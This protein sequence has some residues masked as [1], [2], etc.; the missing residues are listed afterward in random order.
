VRGR[1]RPN[2][3]EDL[4][5]QSVTFRGRRRI[6]RL[7]TQIHA[8]E[9]FD[10]P[11]AG[12]VRCIRDPAFLVA[13]VRDGVGALSPWDRQLLGAARILAGETGAV[14]LLTSAATVDGGRA[15]ADRV[16]VAPALG[17]D[18]PGR[19]A[20]VLAALLAQ[21][22][23]RHTLLAESA[24]SGDLAR[25]VAAATGQA[26]FTDAELVRSGQLARPARARQ[27]ELTAAPTALIGVALDVAAEYAG[28]PREAAPLP[29]LEI[30]SEPRAAAFRGV[31]PIRRDPGSVPLAEADFVVA[32]GN[33]VTDFDSFR[34][35]VT[36][37]AATPGASRAVCD[38][39]L[40]PRD[41]QVGASGTVLDGSCYL[42]F[43]IA[44]APQHLQGVAR[45]EHVIAVNTDLHAAMIKRAA[46]AIVADAQQVMPALLRLVRAR[47]GA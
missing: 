23:P 39:G 10:A 28:P 34:A 16:V 29:A 22:R 40:M 17:D 3:R 35:L 46:L 2:P 41:R 37:L 32:A 33:G 15:G 24:A 5:R 11:R 14:L 47:S 36:A 4:S 44:G 21:H 25:R 12:A 20:A 13:V 9:S 38:A 42:A 26:L 18:D 31:G 30:G 8:D 6:D 7:A 43:G 1:L 19:R 45:V 27:V